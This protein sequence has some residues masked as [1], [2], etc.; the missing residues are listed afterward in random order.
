MHKPFPVLYALEEFP[1]NGD[2]CSTQ[3]AWSLVVLV[4]FVLL[5]LP[6]VLSTSEAE[7][8]QLTARRERTARKLR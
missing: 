3:A 2:G 8:E 6:F 4:A 1:Q 5:V 7:E